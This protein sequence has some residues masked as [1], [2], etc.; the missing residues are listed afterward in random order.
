MKMIYQSEATEC[1]LACLAMMASH[2][3]HQETLNSLRQRYPISTKGATLQQLIE[4]SQGLNFTA[5]ALKLDIDEL[6]NLKLPCILH[7]NMNHFVVLREVSKKGIYICDPAQGECF[8]DMEDVDKRFT[9]IALE[10][11][12]NNN[13]IKKKHGPTLSLKSF[14][15]RSNGLFSQLV[16]LLL[17]ALMLQLFILVMPFYQ[18]IVVDDVLMRRDASLLFAVAL[19]FACVL[20]CKVIT[21]IFRGWLILFL[22]SQLSAQMTSNLMQHLMYLPYNFF[23]SRHVG[24]I[25]S[26]FNSLHKIKDIISNTFIAGLIDG[27]MAISVAVLMFIYSIEM[28]FIVVLAVTIYAAFRWCIYS[29]MYKI[30]QNG[31]VASANEQTHF[32]E[33][34]RGIKSISLYNKQSSRISDWQNR[35]IAALNEQY[36][37]GKWQ[38]SHQA[39]NSLIFGI[40]NIL[41]IYIAA[42]SVMEQ[43][44]SLGMLFAFITYK[45]QF[46]SRM[47]SLINGIFEFRLVSL[48]LSRVED[49]ALTEKQNRLMASHALS[50]AKS[51]VE[52][53]E[54]QQPP[55]ISIKHLRFRYSQFEPFILDDISLSIK[56]G[57]H[58]AIIGISGNGKT[59]FL[60]ILLGLLTPTD[61]K[62]RFNATSTN[63]NPSVRIAS[64]MQDDQL[65][66][67]SILD[68]ISFFEEHVDRERI[69]AC[70][71][72]AQIHGDILR[73]PMQYQSVI[74]D[75][76][77]AL[78]AGQ[79]QR[80]LLARALYTK[81]DCLVLDEATSH[82][83]VKTERMV[84]AA[85]KKMS[86][87]RITV[88]HRKETIAYADEVYA[89]QKG[90]LV[91]VNPK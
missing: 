78:S 18:Q 10:V 79:K 20:V 90:K 3:G 84:N 52:K 13:F 2:Y 26:R 53:N 40:E 12:P 48:H 24:D 67:G 7:W 28:A 65:L 46:T 14:L 36:R 4:I 82:L 17:L 42:L 80:L 68:N 47:S 44:L 87:T 89:L 71:Q 22:N 61:G 75:M 30:S 34:I 38:V 64:V 16:K 23:Q 1:G 62:I 70:A 54:S 43:S 83:D 91:R 86:I 58:I 11:T 56:Q 74:G 77:S 9:G 76:G 31:I 55:H 51:L 37:L 8:V 59:T 69:V 25:V 88:A 73:M 66:A 45:T 27:L 81:P 21:E 50:D 57:S 60:N 5:R 15:S 63:E 32:L 19:G 29:P 33:S 49:I 6:L 39:V 72:I 41:V 35:Y 85:I